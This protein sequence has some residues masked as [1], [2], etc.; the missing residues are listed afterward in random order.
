M[1]THD[2]RPSAGSPISRLTRIVKLNLAN[3]WTTVILPWVIILS[4]FAL[5]QFLLSQE[6]SGKVI[7]AADMMMAYSRKFK[8]LPGRFRFQVNIS[9]LFDNTDIIPVRLSTSANAL[10]G[11]SLPGGRGWIRG[12]I[13]LRRVRPANPDGVDFGYCD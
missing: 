6:I 4:I 10:D 13:R 1:T 8:G 9:N 12:V 7:T 5:M 3:P 2:A 11:Y